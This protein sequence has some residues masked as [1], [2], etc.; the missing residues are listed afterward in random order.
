MSTNNRHGGSTMW[1]Y[2]CSACSAHSPKH[3]QPAGTATQ[4]HIV[5]NLHGKLGGSG[6][7][8]QH[9]HREMLP[10]QSYKQLQRLQLLRRTLVL[11]KCLKSKVLSLSHC[12]GGQAPHCA[13]M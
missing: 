9:N 6:A 8:Y 1:L 11:Q 3:S 12:T 5:R 4:Q 7:L 2:D 10:R 13:S